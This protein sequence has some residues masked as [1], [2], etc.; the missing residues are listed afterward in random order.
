MRIVRAAAACVAYM[1]GA[2]TL[3]VGLLY[4]IGP[5]ASRTIE[6]SRELEQSFKTASKYIT[7]FKEKNGRMPTEQEF[8]AWAK[9]F[10]SKPYDSPNG[11]WLKVSSFPDE[12]IKQ[13]GDP[14]KE[15]FLLVYWRGEWEEYYASWANRTSLEF[16]ESKYYALGSKYADGAVLVVLAVLALVGGR[17]MWPNPSF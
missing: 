16:D 9:A 8:D 3:L 5:G 7:S 15:S 10:P 12:A 2:L 11:M 1:V 14:P 4:A 6:H 17:K 13:F